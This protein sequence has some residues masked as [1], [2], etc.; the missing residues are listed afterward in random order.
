MEWAPRLCVWEDER[1]AAGGASGVR[2]LVN[3][4]VTEKGSPEKNEAWEGV[5]TTRMASSRVGDDGPAMTR[6]LSRRR[7]RW[8]VGAG[9]EE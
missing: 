2:V 3:V 6:M 1:G 5:T 4:I 8:Q 7:G 9:L